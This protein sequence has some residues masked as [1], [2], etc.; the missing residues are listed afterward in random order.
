M[1]RTGSLWRGEANQRLVIGWLLD[2]L[3]WTTLLV[4][5]NTRR[6]IDCD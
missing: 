6:S 5:I 1:I 3:P 4:H 2:T